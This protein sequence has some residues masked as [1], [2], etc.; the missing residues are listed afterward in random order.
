MA[1]S[2]ITQGATFR[3]I[4]N[5]ATEDGSPNPQSLVASP[6]LLKVAPAAGGGGEPK[7]GGAVVASILGLFE[8]ADDDHPDRY[9]FSLET[10]SIPAGQYVFNT[11]YV[12]VGGDIVKTSHSPLI[13]LSSAA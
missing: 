11:R 2:K 3:V 8:A 12:L 13:I 4:E 6:P 10:G 9:T 1:V 7:R 5:I